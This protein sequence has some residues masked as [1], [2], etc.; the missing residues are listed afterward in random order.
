LGRL[1]RLRLVIGL[2]LLWLGFFAGFWFPSGLWLIWR[3][4]LT[5]G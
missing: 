5:C 2:R 4:G 3:G 1:I